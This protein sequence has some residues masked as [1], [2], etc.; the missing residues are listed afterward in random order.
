VVTGG[1]T[2]A[3]AVSPGPAESDHDSALVTTGVI[4]VGVLAVAFSA[5]LI[6]AIAAPALAVAFWRNAFGAFAGA[7]FTLWS[8]REEL[9]ALLGPERRA[10]YLAV[11]AGLALALHFGL[12]I[13]SLRLT[14]VTASTALATTT[15]LWT[16][17]MTRLMG[18]VVPRG[19]V[20]G[21]VV[22]I[23]GVLVDTGVDAAGSEQALQG[24]LLALGGGAAG[25]GYVVAGAEVRRTVG[26]ATYT[27]VAYSTC[28]VVLLAVCLASGT[29]LSGYSARTWVELGLLTLTAQLLG[30][31]LLNRA[32]RSAGATTV[33]LS[34]LLEVPGASLV[35]WMWLGQVP[36]VAVIPG[37]ALVLAGIALVIRTQSTSRRAVAE[38]PSP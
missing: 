35:A 7:P 15:P 2:P 25:A 4:G 38:A 8:R 24:D 31:S 22:A 17:V 26:T 32:L 14:S 37:A 29:S 5:P 34:I 3:S 33:A 10:F 19:V 28:A 11:V 27:L 23:T 20:L 13:P 1:R 6:T 16:V 18:D 9:R 30:H 12:W 36:P 21:V